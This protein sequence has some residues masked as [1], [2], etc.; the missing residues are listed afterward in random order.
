MLTSASACPQMLT[1]DSILRM[2]QGSVPNFMTIQ[3]NSCW[4]VSLDRSSEPTNALQRHCYYD[5]YGNCRCYSF[6]L[7]QPFLGF[8][9]STSQVPVHL[10]APQAT[11]TSA[12]MTSLSAYQRRW[13]TGRAA[14]HQQEVFY[15]TALW[16]AMKKPDFS[17]AL[18]MFPRVSIFLKSM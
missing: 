2:N 7:L 16:Q 14:P 10:S 13:I 5:L 18:P 4:D 17:L 9:P 15:C 12:S 3:S 6:T 1:N 11:A 8:N